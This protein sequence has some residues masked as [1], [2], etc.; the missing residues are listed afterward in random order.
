MHNQKGPHVVS[1]IVRLWPDIKYIDP[2]RDMFKWTLF[3]LLCVLTEGGGLVIVLVS[4]GSSR[5]GEIIQILSLTP[6]R[7][8]CSYGSSKGQTD[9][10]GF[11]PLPVCPAKREGY[12]LFLADMTQYS[13]SGECLLVLQVAMSKSHTLSQVDSVIQDRVQLCGEGGGWNYRA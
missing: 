7:V 12:S 9:G 5:W 3:S 11:I 1:Q 4:Y 8:Q 2:L 10:R 6:S 13:L